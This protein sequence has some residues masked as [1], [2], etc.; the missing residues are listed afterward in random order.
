M[1]APLARDRPMWELHV[2]D[3]L[4]DGRTA[5]VAK[6]HHALADGLRAIELGVDLDD[7]RGVAER[8]ALRVLPGL[9][10]TRKLLA[11]W[12]ACS[13]RSPGCWTPK[14]RPRAHPRRRWPVRQS[15]SPPAS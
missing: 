15:G 13:T 7:L 11:A 14:C 10:P 1:A 12:L 5:V 6:I 9:P 4:A 2:L 3:G 8:P